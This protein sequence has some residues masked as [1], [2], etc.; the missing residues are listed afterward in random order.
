MR[1]CSIMFTTFSLIIS[2]SKGDRQ[3]T[4]IKIYIIFCLGEFTLVSFNRTRLLKF[5]MC[6][7]GE[8]VGSILALFAFLKCRRRSF[9]IFRKS[10]YSACELFFLDRFLLAACERPFTDADS[11][12][13][14]WS[15]RDLSIVKTTNLSEFV[16]RFNRYFGQSLDY[17]AKSRIF[18]FCMEREKKRER[19]F[20]M[21]NLLCLCQPNGK[22]SWSFVTG[23]E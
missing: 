8:K 20:R 18:G 6:L 22:F 14:K 7:L 19:T 11:C 16:T 17:L 13:L 15:S 5:V 21:E 10:F 23:S 2:S 9:D 3:L 1:D 12:I 4:T